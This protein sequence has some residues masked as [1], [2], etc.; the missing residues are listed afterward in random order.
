MDVLE[1]TNGSLPI[2]S[3]RM[4]NMNKLNARSIEMNIMK[5]TSRS[6]M[7]DAHGTGIETCVCL[8]MTVYSYKDNA[9]H[10]APHLNRIVRLSLQE[11]KKDVLQNLE[12]KGKERRRQR[13]K[14]EEQSGERDIKVMAALQSARKAMKPSL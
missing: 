10:R 11:R 6:H 13:I 7:H 8:Y 5:K 3:D 14:L 1:L 4:N 2:S 9:E 12:N